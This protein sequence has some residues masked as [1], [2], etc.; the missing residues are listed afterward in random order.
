MTAPRGSHS[1]V[2]YSGGKTELVR[3]MEKRPFLLCMPQVLWRRMRDTS[4]SGPELGGSV[5]ILGVLQSAF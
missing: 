3:V 2:M 1:E 4:D 5:L